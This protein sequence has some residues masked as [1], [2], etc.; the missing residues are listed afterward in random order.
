MTG[1]AILCRDGW[2]VYAI[3]GIRVPEYV[4]ERPH[5]ITTAA[6]DGEKN[7]EVRRVLIERF[8]FDRYLR[9][10]KV[11]QIQQD[12]FGRLYRKEVEGE[13]A[14]QF[15]R[16]VNSTAEP[17]GTFKEYCLPTRNTVKTAHEAVAQS[18]GLT[19]DQYSPHF[20]S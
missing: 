14:M 10:A 4:V 7:A 2:P 18:F 3:H 9:E 16:V 20:E 17:D 12:D 1:P 11:K 19:I 8:G 6:I 13:P 15:V 5:E